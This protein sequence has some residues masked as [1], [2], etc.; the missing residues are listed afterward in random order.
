MR[1]LPFILFS[2]FA[3]AHPGHARPGWVHVHEFSDGILI[4][5]GLVAAGM[6]YRA[7]KK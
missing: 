7:W 6:L 1:Y 4:A 2:E 3:M 5:V